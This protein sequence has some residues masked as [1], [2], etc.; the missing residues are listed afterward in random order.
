VGTEAPVE[1][2]VLVT[3]ELGDTSYVLVSEGEA[4]VVDPQRDG[5][6]FVAAAEARRARIRG[7]V[8]THVHNDYV[9]GA[10][11]LRSATGAEIAA[12]ARGGYA[13]PHRSID[14]GDEIR[15][16]A[17]TLTAWHTPGHTPEHTS[18]VVREG[19]DPS[20]VAILTGGSLIVG[21]AGRTDLLGPERTDELSREQ[22]RSLRRIAELPGD[23]R[24]LP[25]HGAG[26]FCTA[27]SGGGARTS[28]IAAERLANRALAIDDADE[29]V[30]LRTAD[31]PRYPAYYAH[32]APINRAGPRVAGAPPEVPALE[33]DEVAALIASG[34][35][36]V[37]GRDRSCFAES[38]IPSSTNVELGGSFSAYVG[39][40]FA[41][42]DPLVLIAPEPEP[43]SAARAAMQLF[44]IG[45]ENLKGYLAGGVD[46]WRD[47]GRRLASYPVAGL[48]ELCGE[49]RAGADPLILDVRQEVEHRE[50][51]VEGS[52]GVFVADLPAR[53]GELPRDRAPWVICASG[54]RASIAASILDADGRLVRLV[55]ERGV[56]DLMAEC[57]PRAAA[58]PS[59]QARAVR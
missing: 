58:D 49:I 16:G 8:E 10:C 30:R 50:G 13:F 15:V 33:P 22:F 26:S 56:T 28:T 29:F 6:R 7:V 43:G 42:Q 25:T 39:W 11:E 41:P 12:P 35:R 54:L 59:P 17:L 2:E 5:W 18:Y 32:M 1:L 24:V 3:V 51:M 34:A 23:V 20:P 4:V 36:V 14:D 52:I 9:S 47:G 38:H 46:A 31:L 57:P 45:F 55:S 37:D 53:L 27:G 40:L 21:A 44:R 19:D 48:D